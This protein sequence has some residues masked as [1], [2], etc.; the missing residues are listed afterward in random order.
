MWYHDNQIVCSLKNKYV[1]GISSV[2]PDSG[3]INPIIER[4]NKMEKNDLS[5]LDKII[6]EQK[7]ILGNWANV[8]SEAALY[9][10]YYY[11]PDEK[12]K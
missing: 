9:D 4:G 5:W 8:I 10:E 7:K 2:R 1:P 3:F 11:D 12:E 6:E